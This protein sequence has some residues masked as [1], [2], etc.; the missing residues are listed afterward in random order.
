MA[1]LDHAMLP[2]VRPGGRALDVS[3]AAK[4]LQEGI[5]QAKART[6]KS[7]GIPQTEAKAAAGPASASCFS[8]SKAAVPVAAAPTDAGGGG[9]RQRPHRHH[10]KGHGH[11][12]GG[13]QNGGCSSSSSEQ[14][15]KSPAA[16]ML[17]AA[18]AWVKAALSGP[19]AVKE[20]LH[21]GGGGC[22]GKGAAGRSRMGAKQDGHAFMVAV[23]LLALALPFMLW[24]MS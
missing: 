6:T 3:L 17:A 20:H 13:G 8:S 5:V 22:C 10:H 2:H 16:A 21:V 1:E 12:H 4:N 7:S 14:T 9:V 19:E 18:V 15:T 24:W 11:S 23:L